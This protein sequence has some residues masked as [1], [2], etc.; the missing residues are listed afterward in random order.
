MPYHVERGASCPASKPSA[1]VKSGD[2]EVM[3]CHPTET[4]AD[5]QLAAL[6]ANEPKARAAAAGAAYGTVAVTDDAWLRERAEGFL[7][8]GLPDLPPDHEPADPDGGDTTNTIERE[9][10]SDGG[11]VHGREDHDHDHDVD[12]DDAGGADRA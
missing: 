12:G 2:G 1:V 11:E 5:R 3:G 10:T 4:A 8:G 9:G 6:Y 7:R